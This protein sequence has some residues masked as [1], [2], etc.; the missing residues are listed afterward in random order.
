VL[1][2]AIGGGFEIG[3]NC[4]LLQFDDV[5]I[6]LDCGLRPH[7]AGVSALPDLD[8][9]H[10]L[11]G[12]H[13]HALFVTH[14]HR[15]HAGAVGEFQRRYPTTPVVA[16]R[17]TRAL[18]AT[19][20][21][22]DG[23]VAAMDVDAVRAA[24]EHTWFAVAE[25][26]EAA[27]TPAGHVVGAAAVSLRGVDASA[28]FCL[29]AAVAAH[30]TVGPFEAPADFEPDVVVVGAAGGDRTHGGRKRMERALVDAVA[31]VV[32]DGG[33]VVVVA[34]AFGRAQEALLALRSS[35][36]SGQTPRFSV[37]VGPRGAAVCEALG[38]MLD[39]L[40]EPLR[41]YA[42]NSRQHVFWGDDTP[43]SPNIRPWTGSEPRLWTS[44][45]YDCA[46]VAMRA[47]EDAPLTEF[48]EAVAGDESAAIFIPTSGDED[49]LP[50]TLRAS[51]AEGWL[52]TPAG[53]MRLACRIVEYDVPMHADQPQLCGLVSSLTPKAVVL[54]H[55]R[56]EAIQAVRQ[57]LS[58]GRP[59]Y[60]PMNG[61][62]FDPLAEGDTGDAPAEAPRA[63]IE[64][65]V[66]GVV[67]RFGADAIAHPDF[68]RHFL[69]FE[70]LEARFDGTRLTL[71]PRVPSDEDG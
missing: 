6:V 49:A 56:P 19:L 51:L 2:T 45:G 23:D 60:T 29:D 22:Q 31:D 48:A 37:C 24:D 9:L 30:R 8:R 70:R 1:Y 46:V 53:P 18:L 69:G 64:S 5:N 62:T 34:G 65:D 57:K 59:V 7:V 33:R 67:V 3:A 68:R 44:E 40:A 35:M 16:T 54:T 17:A 71:R 41:R 66:D 47:W 20:G 58:S 52:P 61:D 14:A 13:V 63:E 15:D 38:G 21:A 11:T 27:L 26:V 28:L 43:G 4:H 42:E 25:G 12:G 50:D 32:R 55:G 39:D 10:A 36:M